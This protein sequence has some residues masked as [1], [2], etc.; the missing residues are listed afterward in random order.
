VKSLSR[1]NHQQLIRLPGL[2]P[3]GVELRSADPTREALG[4]GHSWPGPGQL[5]WGHGMSPCRSQTHPTLQMQAS[6][7]NSR[8]FGHAVHAPRS[9]LVAFVIH[10]R[11]LLIGARDLHFR[12]AMRACWRSWWV[13]GRHHL[14][15]MM[16]NG[17]TLDALTRVQCPL[18]VVARGGPRCVTLS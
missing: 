3:I 2:C 12:T 11:E 9:A 16:T 8:P 13:S 15:Q 4:I 7:Q 1:L 10:G 17:S 18:N 6:R 14:L 5:S